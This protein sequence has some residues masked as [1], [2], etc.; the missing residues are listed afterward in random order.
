MSVSYIIERLQRLLYDIKF[1]AGSHPD[2][3]TEL[4]I[5]QVENALRNVKLIL[6]A[7]MEYTQE[8]EMALEKCRDTVRE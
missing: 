1:D 5:I 7:K 6:L 3:A 2:P 4:S 8:L